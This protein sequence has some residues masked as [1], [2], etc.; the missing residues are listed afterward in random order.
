MLTNLTA[1]QSYSIQYPRHPILILIFYQRLFQGTSLSGIVTILEI[2][3]RVGVSIISLNVLPS[4]SVYAH[5]ES[6]SL[7]KGLYRM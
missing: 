7:L 1:I 3:L 2:N 6:I 5:K 4:F